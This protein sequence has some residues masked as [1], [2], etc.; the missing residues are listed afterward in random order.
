MPDG[1]IRCDCG[2]TPAEAAEHRMKMHE[3]MNRA[4]ARRRPAPWEEK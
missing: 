4:R 2:D 1:G 3:A